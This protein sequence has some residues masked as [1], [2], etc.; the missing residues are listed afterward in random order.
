MTFRLDANGLL[1]VSAKDQ[2]TG[3]KQNV[4]VRPDGGLSEAEIKR[5]I[6]DAEASKEKDAIRKEIVEV[7]N[8]A[9]GLIYNTEKSLEEHKERLP[10][11]LVM[12]VEDEV[13]RMNE[14]I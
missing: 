3:R 5:M 7:K 14:V 9:D 11:E 8:K 2:A 10:T 12:K 1:D 13:K 6:K 4:I